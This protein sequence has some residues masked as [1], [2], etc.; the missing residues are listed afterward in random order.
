MSY[1]ILLSLHIHEEEPLRNVWPLPFSIQTSRC[2][3]HFP[4]GSSHLTSASPVF[5]FLIWSDYNNKLRHPPYCQIR[6]LCPGSLFIGSFLLVLHFLL[7]LNFASLT[8]CSNYC[9]PAST[10]PSCQTTDM[11]TDRDR[12][13]ILPGLRKSN[14]EYRDLFFS[15]FHSEIGAVSEFYIFSWIF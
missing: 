11:L 14:L 12:T 13:E 15:C 3:P 6:C 5:H 10:L 2:P 8:F 1:I 7:F 9:L 4:S